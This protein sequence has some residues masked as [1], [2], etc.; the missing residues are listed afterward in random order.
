MLKNASS[1]GSLVCFHRAQAAKVAGVLSCAALFA[2]G[3]LSAQPT[4]PMHDAWPPAPQA[5]ASF[6]AEVDLGAV[7]QPLVTLAHDGDEPLRLEVV[8]LDEDGDQNRR[9]ELVLEPG[10]RSILGLESLASFERLVFVADGAFEAQVEDALGAAVKTVQAEPQTGDRIA[11]LTKSSTQCD[12]TWNLSCISP[13]SCTHVSGFKPGRVENGNQV[14]WNV[15]TPTGAWTTVGSG[16]STTWYSVNANGCPT[17]AYNCWGQTYKV[18]HNLPLAGPDLVIENI[19]VNPSS[20]VSGNDVTIS[21]TIRNIGDV[22]VTARYQERIL[23]KPSSGSAQE[24]YVT[25]TKG[26][27]LPPNGTYQVVTNQEI[28]AAAG[29]YTIQV[30]ADYGQAVAESDENNLF[31]GATLNVQAPTAGQ[32]SIEG[33]TYN[34]SSGNGWRFAM[35]NCPQNVSCTRY[36]TVRNIGGSNAYFALVD[37]SDPGV[38][39]TET[40]PTWVTPGGTCT[41]SINYTMYSP[42]AKDI[43]GSLQVPGAEPA[44]SSYDICIA[45]DDTLCR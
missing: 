29:N 33:L 34:P 4:K 7:T 37:N 42:T 5:E 18:E 14:Y 6:S 20:V 24:L 30:E 41:I 25:S 43:I 15:H 2:V 39:V 10:G 21:Y 40:C 22:T 38:T 9:H 13:S 36:F 12:G 28:N 32:L 11:G 3:S 27:D 45:D 23:L 8:A 26:Q 17:R 35:H 19:S 16:C 1:Y 44:Q 31:S